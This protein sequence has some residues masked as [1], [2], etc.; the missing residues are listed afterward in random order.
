[1]YLALKTTYKVKL[2]QG[3]VFQIVVLDRQF[4]W[5]FVIEAFIMFYRIE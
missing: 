4:N 2:L 3:I 5:S 1:M